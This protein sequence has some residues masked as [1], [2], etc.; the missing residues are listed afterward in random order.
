MPLQIRCQCGRTLTVP[1]QRAGT[2]VLCPVCSRV[3]DIPVAGKAETSESK[4]VGETTSKNKGQ[5]PPPKL[6]RPVPPP[7]PSQR[8]HSA[9]DAAASS[10]NEPEAPPIQSAA[11][12]AQSSSTSASL[13]ATSSPQQTSA[14]TKPTSAE[15]SQRPADK[16]RSEKTDSEQSNDTKRPSKDAAPRA[17]SNRRS[18]D[19]SPPPV[20]EKEDVSDDSSSTFKRPSPPSHQSQRAPQPPPRPRRGSSEAKQSPQNI[21]PT[22][23]AQPPPLP[24]RSEFGEA[25][26]DKATPTPPPIEKKQPQPGPAT[27]KSKREDSG[28]TKSAAETTESEPKELL[29]G[30]EHDP[31]KKATVYQLGAGMAI[32]ALAGLYPAVMEVV[33]HFQDFESTGIEPWAY[34]VFL[35]G[36]LHLAYALYLVQLPDWSTTWVVMF[37]A[38]IT[39]TFFAGGLGISLMG[40]A[41]NEVI[42]AM[43][44]GSLH[45]SGRLSLWCFLMTTLWSTLTYFFTRFSLRWHKAFQLAVAPADNP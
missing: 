9:K 15:E 23:A 21:S 25:A 17:E 12:H 28:E 22:A 34:F 3:V 43:G 30:V 13:K 42:L 7:I 33:R 4:K 6:S 38:A 2:Q 18:D 19:P 16:S 32:L 11:A 14:S 37:V 27:S 1:E 26:G 36:G 41:D 8:P 5:Q 44:L 29:R 10:G 35:L 20:G 24:G 45:A 31:G 39:A 40:S